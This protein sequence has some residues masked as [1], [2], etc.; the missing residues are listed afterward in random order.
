MWLVSDKAGRHET[1]DDKKATEIAADSPKEIQNEL[2]DN[3]A[4][5]AKLP[6]TFPLT[7]A[8]RRQLDIPQARNNK[9]DKQQS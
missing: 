9:T 3:A 1:N 5:E 6:N 2:P 8:H 4:P 7:I